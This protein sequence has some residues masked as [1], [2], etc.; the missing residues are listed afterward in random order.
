MNDVSRY[1]MRVLAIIGLSMLA[2]LAARLWYL[3]VMVSEE[4]VATARSNITRVISV[5]AP[6]GRI[7]DVDGRV[8]VGNRTTTVLTMNRHELAEAGFDADQIRAMLTEVAV[9]INR[10]G[11][12][13]KVSDVE[14]A[15][16]DPSYGRYDDVPIA[17]DVGGELLVFF[18]ERPDR[19]PGV[20]VAES[21]VRSYL[22]GDLASHVLGW[23]GPVNDVE[24]RERQPPAGKGYRLR[25]QI[26][27][28]GVELMF[29]NDLR[30]VAGRKVVEVDR[31]GEIVRQ[32]EDLFVSPI[33]GDDIVLSLD[34]DVQ[35]LVERE[36][37]RSIHLARSREPD[38]DPDDSN[39][40]LP[41]FDAPGGA[42]VLLDPMVGSVV[43]MASY[44][45]YD[46]NDSI[47]GFSFEQ[48]T[49]LNDPANDLPMFNRAIQGEYA[50]GSTFKLFT[51]HAAWH[52]EVFGVGA[53]P[54][55][56]DPWDDPGAYVLRACGD[57]DPT[58]P[59]PGCR[60]RNAGEKQYERVDLTRSLT[61]SSD[62]YYYRIGESIYT[63]P[64]HPD[65]AIQD[66]AT[67]YGL[68][69][70]SGITLPFE[71]DG[72]LPTP[73]NRRLRHEG[74]PV[75]FPEWGWSTGDNVITAIGQGEVLV[76]PLQLTNAF[77]TFANGGVR[78]APNVVDRVVDRDGSTVRTFG[79]RALSTVDIQP[80][81]R[82]RVLEGL[83]GVTADEEGTAYWAFNSEATDGVYFPLDEFPIAAKTGTA[84][85]RGKADTSIFAAFGPANSPTHTMVAVLE[86]SGFG[87]SVAAPLVARVL[88][89][90]LEDTVPEAP[91]A[92]ER[93]ARSAALPLCV[94]WHRWR[95]GDTL[96]RLEAA[97]PSSGE[98]GGPV[99]DAS[100]RVVVRGIR[101]DCEDL[102]EDVLDVFDGDV[103][104]GGSGG[105]SG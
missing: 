77:A 60:Y 2:V 5:P 86:E 97:D 55:A 50:P 101:V 25:D 4:A 23:V 75:A 73:T 7:L 41:T 80:G 84:E 39:R 70:E 54:R 45:S 33:P 51:A 29:E 6:R 103:A 8:M 27:K 17:H 85:V 34:V 24:L 65:T 88:K 49:A 79:P 12:L 43:A 57:V 38:Q 48:W 18:G 82:L 56:D 98:A 83:S 14:R 47:G 91:L 26:G 9:E 44:P 61:V 59:P 72:Y 30:G 19:F 21:T 67:E 32:R 46:P 22:Y 99:L 96:D 40:L 42:V 92:A 11:Q 87:S 13:V 78:F 93:Y 53:V 3:Q 90:V 35:Y 74:N 16:H 95:T 20:S 68:G 100:G 69:L 62:V 104:T 63:N 1:R 52:E 76:T 36:L 64:G 81:F 66:A 28:A 58:D 37:E 102:I 105:G 94:A 31:L 71:Q 15:L 89:Q 10:S